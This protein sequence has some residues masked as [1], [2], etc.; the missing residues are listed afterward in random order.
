MMA[1][2]A[3]GALTTSD[4]VKKVLDGLLNVDR[5]VGYRLR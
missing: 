3:G 4:T 5:N 1:A 2:A